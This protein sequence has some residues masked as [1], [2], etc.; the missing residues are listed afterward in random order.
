MSASGLKTRA[1]PK[2]ICCPAITPAI[3]RLSSGTEAMAPTVYPISAS[4]TSRISSPGASTV[5]GTA[6]IGAA[7]G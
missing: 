5:G 7:M 4:L 3:S 2:P 1:R 6:S